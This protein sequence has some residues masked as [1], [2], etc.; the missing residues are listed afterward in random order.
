MNKRLLAFTVVFTLALF[1]FTSVSYSNKNFAPVAH[2]N[3]P[4]ENSCAKS[5]CHSTFGLQ[6]NLQ[7]R[8]TINIDQTEMDANFEYSPGTT[9]SLQ[10]IINQA[11]TR[12]GFSL[13]MLDENGQ[14]AGTLINTSNDAQ[15]SNGPNGK[16]YVGHTNSLGLSSWEFQWTAPTDSQVITFYSIA[17]LANINDNTNGDSIITKSFSFTAMADTSSTTLLSRNL[18][19]SVKVINNLDAEGVSFYIDVNEVKYFNCEIIDL[20]GAVVFNKEYLLHTGNHLVQIPILDHKGLYF[21]RLSS[22]GA[23]STYKFVN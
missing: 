21:L 11:K 15:V 12:N 19:E 6:Q 23:S 16:T 20:N 22:D 9:Y 4:G 7:D 8:I 3:A 14:M 2:T 1:I 17:N 5:G 13:T 10:F 18:S